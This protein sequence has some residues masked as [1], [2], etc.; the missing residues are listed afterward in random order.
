MKTKQKINKIV[1]L[2][3]NSSNSFQKH[4]I[5]QKYTYKSYSKHRSQQAQGE[6]SAWR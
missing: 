4:G 1:V 6:H 2:R 3:L 5:E